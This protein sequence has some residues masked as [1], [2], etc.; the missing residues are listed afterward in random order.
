MRNTA[1]IL[2]GGAGKRF[3]NSVPKQFLYLE[4]RR[5]IDY[6]VNTFSNHKDINDII[7]VCNN[8]WIKIIKEEYP[9]YNII[10]GGKTRQESS[11]LGLQYC[12][13][14][15]QN[16]LLHD[17]ARPF[18]NVEYITKSIQLLE[19]YEAVNISIP[20]SDTMIIAKKNIIH[21]IPSRENVYLSQTPQSFRY[22]TIL[23]AHK[24]CKELNLTDDIQLVNNLNI[25]CYNLEGS[26]NNIKITHENDL[27]IGRL[28]LKNKMKEKV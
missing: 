2:A 7:I 1:I 10:A 14:E 8:D 27:D 13:K 24:N 18:I 9:N 17:A 21:S 5:I 6:S 28:I 3:N 25:D 19:K 20:L 12:N 15:T 11:L 23:N 22:K 16:V 26:P 4:N